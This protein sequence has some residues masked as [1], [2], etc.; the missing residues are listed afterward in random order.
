MFIS[1]LCLKEEFIFCGSDDVD[2]ISFSWPPHWNKNV[3]HSDHHSKGL[4]WCY[5]PCILIIF[6]V[7]WCGYSISATTVWATGNIRPRVSTDMCRS[8]K[9]VS[10]EWC[11]DFIFSWGLVYASS[12]LANWCQIFRSPMSSIHVHTTWLMLCC[13]IHP[14][15]KQAQ[16]TTQ[17]VWNFIFLASVLAFASW[18]FKCFLVH[19]FAFA[20]VSLTWT[21]MLFKNNN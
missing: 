2:L 6:T 21:Y 5:C 14:G 7:L 11:T 17:E 10:T 9:K 20:S 15:E 19:M 13:P 16:T 3:G 8:E 18:E 12:A 1:F 4:H